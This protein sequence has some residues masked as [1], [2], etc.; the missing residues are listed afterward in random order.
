MRRLVICA[1]GTWNQPTEDDHGVPAPTNVVKMQQA[2][3]SV[4]AKGVSQIVYYH[5]G[6]G[7]KGFFDKLAGGAFGEGLDDI[8]KDCYEF[9]V[10]N[11]AAGDELYLFGFSRGAYTVRSL[12]G[13]VR[14]SGLLK[15]EH[16]AMVKEAFSLYR[17]RDPAKHP[18]SDSAT[19]FRTAFSN[20]V[21]MQCV[22]V[23]DTVGALGVPLGLFSKLN[24]ARFA[25]HDTALSSHTKC[26]FHALAID[27]KRK[28]FE[29]TL[30]VQQQKDHDSDAN[31]LEQAWFSGVHS[32]V[33]GGYAKAGLSDIAFTWMVDRVKRKVAERCNGSTLEFNDAYIAQ[34]TRPDPTDQLYDSMSAFYEELGEG[35]RPIDEPSSNA[36]DVNQQFRG[37]T[38][39]Y[40]HESV[41]ARYG[42]PADMIAP[43]VRDNLATYVSRPNPQPRFWTGRDQRANDL[44][45]VNRQGTVS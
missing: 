5:S 7:T 26:A 28:P 45:L 12:A 25:F 20:E 41:L 3:K 38:W 22:G 21:S 31:W 17:D 9:L 27:E 10:N 42:K 43:K 13:L 29:P 34:M 37:Y 4:D 19:A 33:G 24:H 44:T 14:N 40:V 39:E 6:V 35:K 23:W 8:V 2:I 16:A 11:Y 18:N 32:N 15:Q 36:P 1:D 30:W